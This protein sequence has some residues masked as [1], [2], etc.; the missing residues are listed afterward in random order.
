MKIEGC[1]NADEVQEKDAV[2][3]CSLFA[4]EETFGIDTRK[5]R[6]VLGESGFE[7]VPMSPEFIAGVVPYRGE[8][9]T[10]VNLRALLGMEAS[11]GA[12]CVLVIEDDEA[13]ERFGLVVD[14]VGGV[15]TVSRRALETNPC[16]LGARGKWLFD[17]AYKMDGGL[18]VRLN[19]Q[20]LCP[21]RLSETGLFRKSAN[22]GTDASPDRR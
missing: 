12:C 20:R 16:T 13:A 11:S 6:E 2:S 4:G 15:V 19:P 5:I 18:M 9:L 22:G 7:R 10:A 17:G 8:V 1:N 3:L 14:S 21:S